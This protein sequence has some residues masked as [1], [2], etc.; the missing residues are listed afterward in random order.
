MTAIKTIHNYSNVYDAMPLVAVSLESILN[1]YC[2]ALP[3]L[4]KP[5]FA[6]LNC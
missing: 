1:Y 5:V 4:Y 3:Q 2:V 6:K